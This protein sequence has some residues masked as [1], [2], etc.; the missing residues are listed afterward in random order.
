MATTT[1]ERMLV[2][3][4]ER[5]DEGFYTQAFAIRELAEQRDMLL[6]ALKAVT[7]EQYGCTHSHQQGRHVFV[8]DP[9]C[10]HCQAFQKARE[11]ITK[12]INP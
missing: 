11:A 2:I 4:Q 3:A 12:A 9:R 7:P 5:E 1:T 10:E 6:E 8:T